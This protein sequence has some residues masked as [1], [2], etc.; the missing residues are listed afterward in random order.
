MPSAVS[1]A[2]RLTLA[3]DA[4][5]PSEAVLAEQ[6]RTALTLTYTPAVRILGVRGN[7]LIFA[8]YG[9]S[10]DL[11]PRVLALSNSALA[12]DLHAVAAAADSSPAGPPGTPAGPR[13][14]TAKWPFAVIGVL[15]VVV[16]VLAAVLLVKRRAICAESAY[17]DDAASEAMASGRINT[18][19][20]YQRYEN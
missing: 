17:T 9:S 19:G 1:E 20:D 2:I 14:E 3:T 8:F 5:V 16:L 7:Q 4:T 10:I 15:G 18:G 13:E 12:Q 11:A 6:L